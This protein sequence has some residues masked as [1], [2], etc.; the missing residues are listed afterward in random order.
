MGK[1]F[2]EKAKGGKVKAKGGKMFIVA[3]RWQQ[4]CDSGQGCGVTYGGC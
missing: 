1:N 2:E 3:G 4:H